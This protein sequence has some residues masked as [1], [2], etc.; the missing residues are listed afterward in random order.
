MGRRHPLA[1]AP[2]ESHAAGRSGWL[3]AAVLGSNDGLVSTASLM[4][5]IAASGATTSTIA[6]AGVAGL[7]AG[8]M[9][10]AAGEYVSVSSQRDVEAADRDLEIAEHARQPERERLELVGIYEA[11]GLD[12]ALAEQVADALHRQDPIAAHLRDELGLFEH[13]RARP[14]QAAIASA[15]SFVVGGLIPFLS[16]VTNGTSLAALIVVLTLLGL[17][18]AGVLAARVAGGPVLRPTMRVLIGGC[19]AMAIT[20]LVGSVAH[21]A[22]A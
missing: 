10:M 2:S 1:S 16:L 22:G 8:A 4:L 11:R 5:G 19:V 17:V 21:L 18:S 20:T 6:T 13:G 12:R 3:R 7:V 9:S 14:V 15:S